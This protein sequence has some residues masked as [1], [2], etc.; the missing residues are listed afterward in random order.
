LKNQL[1]LLPLVSHRTI[2]FVYHNCVSNLRMMSTVGS[3]RRG[4]SY[5]AN[6]L[7]GHHDGFK[8]GASVEGCTKDI[9]VGC[10]IFAQGQT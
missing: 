10:F 4:K 6:T 3:Y 8:L 1:L 7:H 2:M 9:D 5:F